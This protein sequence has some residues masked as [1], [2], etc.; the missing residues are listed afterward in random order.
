MSLRSG[1]IAIAFLVGACSPVQSDL[2]GS[3]WSTTPDAAQGAAGTQVSSGGTP[4]PCEV[5]A[6]LQSKCWGCHG[7]QQNYGAPVPLTSWEAVH[8]PTVDGT[9]AIYQRMKRRIHDTASPMPPLGQPPLTAQE[10]ALL[11]A[12]VDQGGPA[13]NGCSPPPGS[14]GASGASGQGG[15]SGGSYYGGAGGMPEGGSGGYVG[16]LPLPDGGAPEWTV[17]DVPVEPDPSECDYLTIHARQDASGAKYNVPSGEQYYCFGFQIPMDPG[18]QGLAFYPEIDNTNVIHHWLLYKAA[19][20]QTDGSVSA[21]VGFHPDGEL[22]AGWAPG[23]P[24]WFMP[25]HVGFELGAG[26]FILEV[27]YFNNGPPTQDGS[28]VRV[29]KAKQPRPTTASISWLGTEWISIP[30]VTGTTPDTY[31]QVPSNC[32]PNITAPIHILRSWPHMHQLGR[33]MSATIHRANGSTEPL[34]DVPFS[35]ANQLQYD[36]P[37]ILNTGDWV[38]TR[39]YYEN[40]SG[41]PVSFGEFTQQEMCYNFVVAYPARAL[42][43]IGLHTNSCNN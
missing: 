33:H 6:A 5:G 38:E 10:I 13:G 42:T 2:D 9:E 3:E 30:G 27:H 1:S 29:C 14:G 25:E 15:G 34:F 20:P 31:F 17:E 8:H 41:V 32:K 18:S 26:S 11:D 35:F 37:A 36:T 22:I 43:A 12:W 7:V 21:C 23:A 4:F 28:G 24:A 39:C 19:L 40:T 16:P